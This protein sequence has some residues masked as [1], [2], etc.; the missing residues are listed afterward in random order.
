M[1]L[2]GTLDEASTLPYPELRTNLLKFEKINIE[3]ECA[4]F[5]IKSIGVKQH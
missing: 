1:L 2:N 4:L 5:R 3:P